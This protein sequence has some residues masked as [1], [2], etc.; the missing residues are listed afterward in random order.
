MRAQM[1][2]TA[3][4]RLLI[5]SLAVPTTAPAAWTQA[6]EARETFSAFAVNMGNVGPTG[7]R[8]VDIGI[9]RWLT[10]SEI[11]VL[12]TALVEK[13]SDGLLGALRKTPRVGYLRL[14]GHLAYDLRYARE[15]PL[16]GGGR[17]ILLA[18]DRRIGFVEARNNGGDTEYPFTAIE[19][20]LDKND[21][22]EGTMAMAAQI[23]WNTTKNVLEIE[24]YSTQP[25]RLN[26]V[27][28][29]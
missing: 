21:T 3:V 27:H 2:V 12:R 14:P 11:E 28:K 15:L 18:T 13:G 17:R 5:C 29:R 26:A 16:D 1:I 22:G 24:N 6:K 23:G 4:G 8:T 7:A 20:R 10:E 25:V 19:L 9:E